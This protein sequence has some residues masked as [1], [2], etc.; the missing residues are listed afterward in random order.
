M[1]AT[2]L[3][4]KNNR[5]VQGIF[6]SGNKFP[7]YLNILKE[8]FKIKDLTFESVNDRLGTYPGFYKFNS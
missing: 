3:I 8:N 1:M 5:K 2:K 6:R 4:K 7:W